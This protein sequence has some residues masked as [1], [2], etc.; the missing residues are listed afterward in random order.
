MLHFSYVVH[1]NGF[2]SNGFAIAPFPLFNWDHQVTF[3][4]DA[5]PAL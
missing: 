5:Q 1:P 2:D 4:S 3:F